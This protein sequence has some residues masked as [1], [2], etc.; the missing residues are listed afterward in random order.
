M[1][2]LVANGTPFVDVGIGVIID[3]GQLSGVVRVTTS[4]ASTREI[5]APRISYADGDDEA[6]EYATNIQIAEL[7]ALNAALAVIRWKKQFGV[8]RDARKD[9]YTGYSIATGE[10]VSE[11]LE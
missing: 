4:T 11:G 10:I 6:N 3:D 2:R 9:F 8:Y 7:N 1:E 5:A